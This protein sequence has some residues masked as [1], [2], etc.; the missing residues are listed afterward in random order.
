MTPLALGLEG[1]EEV[2][3]AAWIVFYRLVVQHALTR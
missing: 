3:T 2:Q 1:Y